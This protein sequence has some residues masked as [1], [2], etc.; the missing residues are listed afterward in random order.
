M[1]R[2]EKRT[3]KQDKINQFNQLKRHLDTIL[4]GVFSLLK[5]ES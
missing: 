2:I 1:E 4:S 5:I 3:K